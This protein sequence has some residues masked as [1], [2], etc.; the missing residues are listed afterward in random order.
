ML[1]LK[2]LDNKV[3]CFKMSGL[4]LDFGRLDDLEVAQE[5]FDKNR[6]TILPA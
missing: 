2:E 4:W 5:I 3:S 6:Q 1:R